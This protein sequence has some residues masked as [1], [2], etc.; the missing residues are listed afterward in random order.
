MSK[1]WEPLY[2]G[3]HYSLEASQNIS[4]TK[5]RYRKDFIEIEILGHGSFGQVTKVQNRLDG[6]FYAIKRISI[7]PNPN[8]LRR[9]LREVIT[10]SKL[11]HQ[12]VLRYYQAWIEVG[13]KGNGVDSQT[14]ELDVSNEFGKFK[15]QS[16]SMGLHSDSI[17]GGDGNTSLSL[18]MSSA[19]REQTDLFGST[20]VNFLQISDPSRLMFGIDASCSDRSRIDKMP[21]DNAPQSQNNN[22]Y[23]YLYIQTEYCARTLRETLDTESSKINPDENWRWFRQMLE[24]LAHIHD[25]GIIHRDLKPSNIFHDPSGDVRIGDLGLATF[26]TS[27]VGTMSTSTESRTQGMGHLNSLSSFQDHT[28]GI[29]TLLYMSPELQDISNEN[30]EKSNYETQKDLDA[31]NIEFYHDFG[32]NY[33]EKIDMYSLGI[34]FFEMWI[35]FNTMHERVEVISRLRSENKFPD[36]FEMAHPRQ[37]RIIRWLLC[38]NPM[39]RPSATQ[40][41]RHSLLPPKLE[42]EHI[43]D[44]L[45][46]LSNP[47]SSFYSQLLEHLFRPKMQKS[48]HRSISE[49]FRSSLKSRLSL[50]SSHTLVV[51][52]LRI[53]FENHSAENFITPT[54]IP[55][56]ISSEHF[57]DIKEENGFSDSSQIDTMESSFDSS[58][59]DKSGAKSSF[60]SRL[61]DPQGRILHPRYDLRHGFINILR[62]FNEGMEI[63]K[64]FEIGSVF[65]S[66]IRN[67]LSS[68][69][70]DESSLNTGIK[71]FTQADFDIIGGD[72]LLSIAEC[73][74][75]LIEICR[76][77]ALSEFIGPVHIRIGS[78]SHSLRKAIFERLGISDITGDQI[79]KILSNHII[80]TPSQ[81][82]KQRIQDV[83]FIS[84]SLHTSRG[85]DSVSFFFGM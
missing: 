35:P 84:R 34:V 55:Y 30:Q 18:E 46:L 63:F 81:A 82:L 6:R 3:I 50:S 62:E 20:G 36:G 17:F 68:D 51:D 4:E 25:H 65:R 83:S 80:K 12:Y 49:N 78:N 60:Y 77:S 53:V 58:L 16:Y 57:A 1:V 41:L 9:I 47:D 5:S 61:L 8:A 22:R 42:D 29:G 70:F 24:G 73:I 37:C 7:G 56:E 64:R 72:Y 71:E 45:R 59:Y 27:R 48:K 13:I 11:H 43:K 69:I 15:D 28:S 33:S 39:D 74:Y 54:V 26:G 79:I 23:Y 40:L 66:T 67:S 52:T 10:L 32:A 75:I 14:I 44:A 31:S 85:I 19:S 38:N 21:T 2:S 76:H